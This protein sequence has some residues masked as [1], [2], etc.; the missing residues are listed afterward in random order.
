MTKLSDKKAS[1]KKKSDP[2]GGIWTPLTPPVYAPACTV[3][4]A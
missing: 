4:T 2:K 1:K 3:N